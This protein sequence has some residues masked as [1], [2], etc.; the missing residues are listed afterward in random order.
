[1]RSQLDILGEANVFHRLKNH[2]RC[3]RNK[4]D[5]QFHLLVKPWLFFYINILHSAWILMVVVA[6]SNSNWIRS[7]GGST[8]LTGSTWKTTHGMNRGTRTQQDGSRR[9]RDRKRMSERAWEQHSLTEFHPKN[10]TNQVGSEKFIFW[11]GCHQQR[12]EPMTA[13]P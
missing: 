4:I 2:S 1:M 6:V 7:T 11:Q 5:I 12:Q 13:N 3:T 9:S 8:P 10:G